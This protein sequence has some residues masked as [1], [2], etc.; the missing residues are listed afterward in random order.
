MDR[1]SE[2]IKWKKFGNRILEIYKTGKWRTIIGRLQMKI[3]GR[4]RYVESKNGVLK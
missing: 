2:T 4:D 3:I 1:E